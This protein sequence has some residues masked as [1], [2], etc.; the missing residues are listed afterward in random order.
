MERCE[1]C[2]SLK[3]YA[4]IRSNCDERRLNGCGCKG[5]HT[6]V[7]GNKDK[8]RDFLLPRCNVLAEELEELQDNKYTTFQV[9]QLY[10]SASTPLA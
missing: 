10:G 1:I 7:Y 2:G 6:G 4:E 8:I 9:G 3:A 5:G